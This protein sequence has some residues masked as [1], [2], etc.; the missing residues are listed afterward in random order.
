MA[1]KILN[2]VLF[3]GAYPDM[4][5]RSAFKKNPDL[6]S[7][8]KAL[9]TE[10]VYGVIRWLGKLDYIIGI[11]AERRVNKKEI[12]N[13][14]RIGIYQLLFLGGV[15]DYAAIFETVNVAKGIYGERIARFVNAILREF[16][17]SRENINYPVKKS[18]PIS[19][20]V[21]N[22]SFPQWLVERWVDAF[23]MDYTEKLCDSLNQIPL[24]TGRVNTLKTTRG[25]L[26]RGIR[27]RDIE[28]VRTK[29][30]PTG[31]SFLTDLN[32]AEIPEFR[33]GLFTVQDEGAQLISYL[34]DPKL[35][36]KIL[37]ACSSPGGKSTHIAELMENRGEIIAC[38]INLS[39]L[40]L[41]ELQSR[42]LGV[43][44]IKTICADAS[45]KRFLE[46]E[47]F[48][49]ILVDAPCSG[50]GTIRRNPDAK[51]KK[52]WS[53]MLELS[54][55]QFRILSE[56]SARLKV[57]GIIVYSVCTLM[58]EENEGMIQRF[59]SAH[60]E[61]KIDLEIESNSPIKGFLDKNGFFI[62]DPVRHNMDGFF[63]VRL[64]KIR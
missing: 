48:D 20:I 21:I 14:L 57:N 62:S 3:E 51:W 2:R 10:L 28:V 49:K 60:P 13:I 46:K 6:T 5:L 29:Y 1:F 34:L 40:K 17:R 32:P 24:L 35:G 4:V 55:I 64:R 15:P 61:F 58:E 45:N 19:Y 47:R 41:V 38:D 56:T 36:E 9:L 39:R 37:D 42:R 50:L 18:N 59:L 7:M 30:S 31:I 43:E 52:T 8:D 54:E 26:I 25:D 44:I 33:L 63:A 27:D 53:D 12:L 23:G 16:L 22:Y 11:L